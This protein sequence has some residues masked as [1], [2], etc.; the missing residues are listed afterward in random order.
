[1]AAQIK[2]ED[3]S[4]HKL[5]VLGLALVV[6]GALSAIAASSA[7]AGYHIAS[8]SGGSIVGNQTTKNEFV[9]DV[10][11]VKCSIA[12]F[13]GHQSTETAATLTVHPEY[14]GC[15]LSGLSVSINTTS[16]SYRFETPVTTPSLHASVKVLCGAGT[17]ISITESLGKGCVVSVGEQGPL[18][19]VTFTSTGDTQ[20]W[21]FAAAGIK[22]TDN[23]KCPSTTEGHTNSTGEYKGAVLASGSSAIEVT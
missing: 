3:K 11:T 10:G 16:C 9:T 22:Y 13:S 14:S 7:F 1:V 21:F 18:S 6:I 23:G 5:K 12:T 17:S 8:V 2:G 15:S 4:M 19:H 20:E